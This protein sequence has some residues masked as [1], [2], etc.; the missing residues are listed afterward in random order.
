MLNGH[1]KLF[2]KLTSNPIYQDSVLVHLWVHLLIH[3]QTKTRQ[4]EYKGQYYNLQPGQTIITTQEIATV[5]GTN[6]TTAYRKLLLLQK[7]NM[8]LFHP[9]SHC[10]VITICKFEEYQKIQAVDLNALLG[11]SEVDLVMKN[12]QKARKDDFCINGTYSV[13]RVAKQRERIENKSISELQ[14]YFETID[15]LLDDNLTLSII[16]KQSQPVNIQPQTIET[17]EPNDFDD[18]DPDYQKA[19]KTFGSLGNFRKTLANLAE[20]RSM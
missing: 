11:S 3:A 18:N 15:L 8:I 10:C 4:I 12:W 5:L 19:L 13:G 20:S 14:S 9:K 17:R 2:R 1:I 16:K 6:R 7:D